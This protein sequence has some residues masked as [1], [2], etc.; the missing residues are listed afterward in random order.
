MNTQSLSTRVQGVQRALVDRS[1]LAKSS[2]QESMRT[3]PML[4]AGVAAGSGLA[5]GLIGRFIHWRNK[6]RGSAATLVVIEAH[7]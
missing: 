4:W 2:M 6:R 5:L 3:Q 1:N 7:C